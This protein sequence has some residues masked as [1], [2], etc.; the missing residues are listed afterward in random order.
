MGVIRRYFYFCFFLLHIESHL[1]VQN[2]VAQAQFLKTASI[3]SCR[4]RTRDN[5][6]DWRYLQGAG[7]EQLAGDW[8]VAEYWQRDWEEGFSCLAE[9]DAVYFLVLILARG[10]LKKWNTYLPAKILSG[11]FPLIIAHSWSTVFPSVGS[12]WRF[13]FEWNMK[14]N[15]SSIVG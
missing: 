13:M 7:E 6:D 8:Y 3:N 12:L 5:A 14:A 11:D 10:G 4:T 2:H 15:D 1:E 9:W